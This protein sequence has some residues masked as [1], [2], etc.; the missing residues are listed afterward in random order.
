MPA[1]TG[2]R[3]GGEDPALAV[4]DRPAPKLLPPL[5]D[6]HAPDPGHRAHPVFVMVVPPPRQHPP[7]LVFTIYLRHDTTGWGGWTGGHGGAFP[8]LTRARSHPGAVQEL[9]GMHKRE[10]WRGCN[11]DALTGGDGFLEACP[12]PLGVWG[13]LAPA[14]AS[15]EQKPLRGWCVPT[16]AISLL[17]KASHMY[18]R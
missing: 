14:A 1:L 9:A 6:I 5:E 4:L 12:S 17:L 16:S 11:W 10:G 18:V 7:V 3:H 2:T 8:Q 15:E 13:Q